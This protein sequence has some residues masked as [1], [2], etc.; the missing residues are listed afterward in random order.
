[1]VTYNRH[2][3]NKRVTTTPA[4]QRRAARNVRGPLSPWAA[5]TESIRQIGR[6]FQGIG[7]V[8]ARAFRRPVT[9]DEYTLAE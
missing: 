8:L 9:R 2:P 5:L 4:R 7:Q 3:L 6:H 1:M